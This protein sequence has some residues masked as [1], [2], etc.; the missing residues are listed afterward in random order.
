[1][2][3]QQIGSI[4]S[5]AAPLISMIPGWGTLAG[6]GLGLAGGVVQSTAPNSQTR[7]GGAYKYGGQLNQVST[8]SA[9]VSAPS[10]PDSYRQGN[11]RL[12]NKEILKA[13][14][15]SNRLNLG[16]KET[17]AAAAKKIENGTAKAEKKNERSLDPAALNT[18]KRHEQR[19]ASLANQQEIMA[20]AKGKRPAAKYA[21]GGMIGGPEY[22]GPGDPAPTDAQPW[23]QAKGDPNLYLN[24]YDSN[25]YVRF[26]NGEYKKVSNPDK[27]KSAGI[28]GQPF[29]LN[30]AKFTPE[31]IQA[32]LSQ[33]PATTNSGIRNT[34]GFNLQYALDPFKDLTP[35]VASTPATTPPGTAKP[36]RRGNSS[37]TPSAPTTT[38]T[39]TPI[40]SR[41]SVGMPSADL[42]TIEMYPTDIKDIPG[43]KRVTAPLNPLPQVQPTLKSNAVA[44]DVRSTTQFPSTRQSADPTINFT[45]GDYMQMTAMA[46]RLVD[47]FRKPERE[48]PNLDTTDIT[49]QYF[50][51]TAQ[52]QQSQASFQN[53]SNSLSTNS[54]NTRR[55]LANNL[56]A[57]KLQA[58]SGILAKYDEMNQSAKAQYEDRKSNQSRFN[59]GQVNYTNDI[60]AQN[61]AAAMNARAAAFDQIGYAGMMLN[62]RR[63]NQ[64][65]INALQQ[66]YPELD[67]SIFEKVINPN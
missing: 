33:Y 11:I 9:Q 30:Q 37:S 5:S 17:F 20:A 13:Y 7:L 38:P 21:Y 25:Y 62:E 44:P 3:Q 1:M 48:R 58:D 67:M 34:G 65:Y 43:A 29:I 54:E 10:A 2:N 59:A 27:Y 26:D 23:M 36:I 53:A 31:E 56:Y 19:M 63:Q 18:I 15:Y 66:R 47:A 45:A 24:P 40:P 57:G 55:A 50:D 42:S 16:P 41:T 61:R 60:N 12:D 52:L 64:A 35:P 8:S 22:D 46:S 28:G 4:L 6:A 51:P 49:R 39:T 32:H 14:V